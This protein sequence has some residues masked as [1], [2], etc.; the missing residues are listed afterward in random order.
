MNA[1][2]QYPKPG[3]YGRPL[4]NLDT[5]EWDLTLTDEGRDLLE[6]ELRRWGNPTAIVAKRLAA[7][8]R[9]LN[10]HGMTWEDINQLAYMGWVRSVY[11]YSPGGC[12]L[13]TLAGWCIRSMFSTALDYFAASKRSFKSVSLHSVGAY[14]KDYTRISELASEA[15]EPSRWAG[16]D[17]TIRYLLE[18]A[19]HQ[20]TRHEYQA[21][22]Q[23][24]CLD[25]GCVDERTFQ[26]MADING[27]SKE[28]VRMNY[29]GALA[30]LMNLI[31]IPA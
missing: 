19:E 29:K 15:D 23:R 24:H 14:G 10:R 5:M 4:F 25:L 18:Q 16:S 27:V 26:E 2:G 1:K 28:A 7:T 8:I 20:M 31:E 22:R 11:R 30:K 6:A 12:K 3:P 17:D 21:F 13:S 9:I